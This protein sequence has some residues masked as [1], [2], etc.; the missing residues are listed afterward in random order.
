MFD[1]TPT[2]L[3]YEKHKD[4]KSYELGNL[5][6]FVFSPIDFNEWFEYLRSQIYSAIGISLSNYS[7]IPADK[8]Q[9]DSK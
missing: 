4:D 8:W 1:E 9:V 3:D 5:I 2:R 6:G 7:P